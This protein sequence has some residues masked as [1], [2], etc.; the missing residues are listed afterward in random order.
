MYLSDYITL[1]SSLVSFYS[2]TRNFHCPYLLY[3]IHNQDHR[4][5]QHQ[6]PLSFWEGVR[7][8]A[9]WAMVTMTSVG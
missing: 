4:A 7:E 5:N 1:K 2:L 8:G 3:L 6:F 9:W